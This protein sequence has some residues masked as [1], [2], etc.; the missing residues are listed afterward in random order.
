[1]TSCLI[2]DILDAAPSLAPQTY[3]LRHGASPAAAINAFTPWTCTAWTG[4]DLFL[5]PIGWDFLSTIHKEGVDVSMAWNRSSS[6]LPI[7]TGLV[8][9]SLDQVATAE[10]PKAMDGST[11]RMNLLHIHTVL[12][13]ESILIAVTQRLAEKHSAE[14]T[15]RVA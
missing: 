9:S 5:G 8:K 10:S 3:H 13:S 15:Q 14:V 7:P 6:T 1:M 2:V 4:T 12:V 11:N